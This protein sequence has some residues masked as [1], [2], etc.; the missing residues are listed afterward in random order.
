M[1][2]HVGFYDLDRIGHTQKGRL[3]IPWLDHTLNKQIKFQPRLGT[4]IIP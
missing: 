4:A 2:D 1:E 3:R